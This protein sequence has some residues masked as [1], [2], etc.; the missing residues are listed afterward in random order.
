MEQQQEH[1][2][3][4]D[5]EQ[6]ERVWE[7]ASRHLLPQDHDPAR[8]LT[9][10]RT[11]YF[12]TPEYA[13]Y[14]SHGTATSRRLRVR[15]YAAAQ[16][17]EAAPVLSGV[18]FLEIKQSANGLRRKLRMRLPPE[19]VEAHLRALPDAPLRPCVT[20]WYA[21][22]ALA[23]EARQL[24]V[25]LDRGLQFCEP[26]PLGA[27]CG[28]ARQRLLARGPALILEVKLWHSIPRWLA[29]GLSGIPEAE[30]FS[31]FAVGMRAAS[32]CGL[33]DVVDPH[34]QRSGFS[35]PAVQ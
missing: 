31:K 20:T 29:E 5:E 2:F 13:Y 22:T 18:C 23:D 28:G 1:K 14:R 4:L 10:V 15:E 26:V 8:P 32:E 34:W 7:V 35:H 3:L 33:L 17:P 19:Q 12:D 11:T 27:P 16:S 30:G 9:Y 21:R 24:R 6:A 25:T